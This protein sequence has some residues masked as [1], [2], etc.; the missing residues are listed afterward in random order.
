MGTYYV[1]HRIDGDE[2]VEFHARTVAEAKA[3]IDGLP[4]S[5]HKDD[6]SIWSSEGYMLAWTHK[7][8][9]VC[10]IVGFA[11]GERALFNNQK[12]TIT[13]ALQA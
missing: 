7:G 6:F 5:F 3:K 10:G 8:A 12:G 4:P 9:W 11:Q 1:M 2:V 13:A